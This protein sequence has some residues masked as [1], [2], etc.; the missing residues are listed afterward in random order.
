MNWVCDESWK[1]AFT[2]AIFNAGGIV[3]TLIFGYTADHLG[4]KFTF[5][6]TNTVLLVGGLIAPMCNT[7]VTY[8]IT[9]FMMGLAKNTY[10]TIFFLLCKTTLMM[11]DMIMKPCLFD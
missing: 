8:S 1:A 2:Q 6:A 9:R 3:G 10:F 7:F 5:L 11:V 4:R